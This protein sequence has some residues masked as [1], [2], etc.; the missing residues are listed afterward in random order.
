MTVNTRTVN[1][2]T[3]E[4]KQ[5]RRRD[6]AAHDS[7]AGSVFG[8]SLMDTLS[9]RPAEDSGAGLTV[10]P[11]PALPRIGEAEHYYRDGIAVAD[12][13][14]DRYLR[15]AYKVGQYVTL[16]LDPK[17]DWHTKAKYFSHVVRR[18]CQPPAY[19]T[20]ELKVFFERLMALAREHAGAEAL[21]LCSEQDE[22]FAVRLGMGQTRDELA[23]DAEAFFDPIVP[24]GEKKPVI[25][26]DEDW[27]Q[28]RMLRNEWV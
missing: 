23:D 6:D 27:S 15:T 26:S 1:T 13:D 25:Y 14:G 2:K 12:R 9:G 11:I 28:L 21:R 19:A 17:A 8:A 4:T 24:P 20:G 5:A 22:L 7:L 18:H 16:A 3:V 10:H